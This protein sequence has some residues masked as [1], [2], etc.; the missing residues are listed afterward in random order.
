M[1]IF[2][3]ACLNHCRPTPWPYI[4]WPLSNIWRSNDQ[5]I[6]GELKRIAWKWSGELQLPLWLRVWVCFDPDGL[7]YT[8]LAQ[9]FARARKSC[10]ECGDSTLP[11]FAEFCCYCGEELYE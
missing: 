2:K 11:A 1:R 10:G 3:L 6:F 4:L 9:R 8:R 7:R 5:K